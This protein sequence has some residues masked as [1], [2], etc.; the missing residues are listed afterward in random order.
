MKL[1]IFDFLGTIDSNQ[2][3]EKDIIVSIKNLSEQYTL[4]IVSSSSSS[5]IKNYLEK[6]NILSCFLDILGFDVSADKT[7]KIKSLLEKYGIGS[8]DTVFIT[9][10]LGDIVEAEK[11]EVRSIG[12]TWGLHDRKTLEKGSPE[13][14]IDDPRD[15]LKTIEN[16]L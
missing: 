8:K 10:T 3:L 1:V 12:V 5:Y 2:E 16:V 4:S 14:I 6:R 7:I 11:C 9:D 13:V 15:L